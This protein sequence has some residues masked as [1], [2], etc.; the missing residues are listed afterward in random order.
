MIALIQLS[1]GVHK[2]VTGACEFS[3]RDKFAIMTSAHTGI[4]GPRI[5]GVMCITPPQCVCV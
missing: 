1:C 3:A 5:G 4:L 2:L